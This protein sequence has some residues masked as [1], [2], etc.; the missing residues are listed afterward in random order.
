[1]TVEDIEHMRRWHLLAKTCCWDEAK[2]VPLLL[3]AK[4][5]PNQRVIQGGKWYEL[6]LKAR[7][8]GDG[9]CGGE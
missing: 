9:V 7:S 1:M 2:Y 6:L 8:S 5:P 4:V 3:A